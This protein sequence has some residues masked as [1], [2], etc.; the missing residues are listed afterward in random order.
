VFGIAGYN[1]RYIQGGSSVEIKRYYRNIF[2]WLVP[3]ILLLIT[4]F[5]LS[6]SSIYYLI[7]QIIVSLAAILIAY[8][9]FTERPRYY[10]AWGIAFILIALIYNPIVH[11]SII[12]GIEV[13]LNLIT[14]IIFFTNWWFVCRT[15]M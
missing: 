11:L 12:M 6:L 1:S 4:L 3:V 5:P 13:S 2:L 15:R 9:L 14:A 8:F 10:I 7:L